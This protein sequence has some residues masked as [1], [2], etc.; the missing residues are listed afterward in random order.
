MKKCTSDFNRQIKHIFRGY[1]RFTPVMKKKLIKLG[2]TVE[3][4]NR[5]V[6]LLYKAG[7][8]IYTFTVAT[9]PGDARTGKN[10]SGNIIRNI[11]QD[12]PVMQ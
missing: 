8:A 7:D 2:F 9:T 6:I 10:I 1:S 3:R 11:G 12:I 4:H 5:H